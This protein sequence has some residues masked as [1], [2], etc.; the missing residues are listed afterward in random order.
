M[1]T[2]LLLS[3]PTHKCLNQN[4]IYFVDYESNIQLEKYFGKEGS[5][6]YWICIPEDA[7]QL[8]CQLQSTVTFRLVWAWITSLVR[9][10][11]GTLLKQTLL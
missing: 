3:V 8:H 1:K 9:A 6:W 2:I 4:L 5:P 7:R 10:S 11:E